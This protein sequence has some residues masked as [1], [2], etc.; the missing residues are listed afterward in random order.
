ML[1]WWWGG[2]PCY[3]VKILWVASVSNWGESGYSQSEGHD[4]TFTPPAEPL[5]VDLLRILLQKGL[6]ALVLVDEAVW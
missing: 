2:S 5:L 4:E 3:Q 6:G 1:G